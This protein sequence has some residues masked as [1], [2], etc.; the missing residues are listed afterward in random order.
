MSAWDTTQETDLG[1]LIET[2]RI[3]R[4]L[5]ALEDLKNG[6][7][8]PLSSLHM[9]KSGFHLREQAEAWK[10]ARAYLEKH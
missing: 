6:Q 4:K 5:V 7:S 8:E 9:A 1:R 10:D 2:E 3:L